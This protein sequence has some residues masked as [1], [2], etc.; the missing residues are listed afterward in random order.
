MASELKPV[1]VR[2]G[3]I[4]PIVIACLIHGFKCLI[5]G[6]PGIGKT[7]VTKAIIATLPPM[8]PDGENALLL[9]WFL[10]QE[11]EEDIGG[12]PYPKTDESGMF[13]DKL[14]FE[15]Q[16][17]NLIN[18]DR[19][20]I[21]FLDDMTHGGARKQTAIMQFWDG[22]ILGKRLGPNCRFI[23][24]C[25]DTT[26]MAGAAPI[27]EPLKSRCWVIYHAVADFPFWE[28]W[29]TGPG[30]IRPD[31]VAYLS[32][33]P[34]SLDAFKPTKMLTQSPSPRTWHHLSDMMNVCDEVGVD[35]FTRNATAEGTVGAAQANQYLRYA[36]MV[37]QAATPEIILSDPYG[38]RI[39]ENASIMYAVTL[40]LSYTVDTVERAELA[41]QY[42]SRMTAEFEALLVKTITEKFPG[43]K[44]TDEYVDYASRQARII[45]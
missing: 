33:N 34:G 28:K 10:A 20:V 9:E 15:K 32:D 26:M 1:Q 5:V 11:N 24:C 13:A 43:A 35:D 22:S 14:L 2:L 39:P 37:K 12:I 16:R 27:I 31:I 8:I 25:N 4:V 36:D 44:A 30:L 18:P 6:N 23:G 38:A 41:M 42:G 19:Y 21:N 40:A 7:E 3:A 17:A 29:A 45:L